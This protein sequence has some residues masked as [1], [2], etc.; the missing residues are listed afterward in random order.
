MNADKHR[1]FKN[2]LFGP[3]SQIGLA[4]LIAHL[5]FVFTP[6]EDYLSS[7]GYVNLGATPSGEDFSSP[8]VPYSDHARLFKRS[9]ET[10]PG[11][12]AVCARLAGLLFQSEESAGSRIPCTHSIPHKTFL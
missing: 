10:I 12:V 5:F 6:L 7:S 1:W 2:P 8:P 3:S 9:L 11:F 4:T